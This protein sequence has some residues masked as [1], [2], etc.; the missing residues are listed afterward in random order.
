MLDTA[1]QAGNFDVIGVDRVCR[2]WLKPLLPLLI[3]PQH[4]EPPRCSQT[5]ARRPPLARE[6]RT[7]SAT[8]SAGERGEGCRRHCRRLRRRR[9]DGM[10]GAGKTG[11]LGASSRTDFYWAVSMQLSKWFH[12][13]GYCLR[14]HHLGSSWPDARRPK[15][16]P[17][18]RPHPLTF[19][20][21][22]RPTSC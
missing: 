9:R 3:C 22:A 13:W 10:C 1:G 8:S 15:L 7:T 17:G 16:T 11:H 21:A 20:R 5:L 14:V 4:L 18:A 19:R 12:I 2:A 6:W